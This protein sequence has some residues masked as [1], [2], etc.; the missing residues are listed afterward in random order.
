MGTIQIPG[1]KVRRA[2][3]TIELRDGESFT[4]AG[5]LQDN[6]NAQIRQYPFIGDVPVLGALFRSN[7]YQRNETELVIVVTART[8]VAHRGPSATPADRFTPPS[9]LELFLLGNQ[10]ATH[11]GNEALDR[12][13]VGVDPH[14]GGIDGPHGHVIY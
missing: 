4:I 10:Q 7:G 14:K 3:T 9:D 11:T 6:Y 5:L 12:V 8:V 13:L 2:S 1:L